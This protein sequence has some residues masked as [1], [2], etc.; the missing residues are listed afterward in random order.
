MKIV[1][2]TVIILAAAVIMLGVKVFFVKGGK[3]PSGHAH[4]SPALRAR[5]VTC[6]ASDRR[7]D[8]NSHKI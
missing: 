2:L 3:F 7:N 5:D 6:A 8:T 4:S 1:L